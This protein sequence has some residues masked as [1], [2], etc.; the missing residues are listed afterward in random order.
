MKQTQLIPN[1]AHLNAPDHCNY[2]ELT[3]LGMK[4][5]WKMLSFNHLYDLKNTNIMSSMCAIV[6]VLYDIY[7]HVLC[8]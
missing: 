4:A 7:Q 8:L 2:I 6:M 5:V 1:V 3:Y